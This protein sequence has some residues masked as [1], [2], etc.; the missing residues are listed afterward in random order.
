MLVNYVLGVVG[1]FF[2]ILVYLLFIIVLRSKCYCFYLIDGES[3]YGEV[4]GFV[5]G[6]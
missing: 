6:V 5:Y 2:N 3:R 4:K 1:V